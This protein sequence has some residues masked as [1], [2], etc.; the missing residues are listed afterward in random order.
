ML[1]TLG[2]GIGGGIIINNAIYRGRGNAGEIGHLCLEPGGKQCHCGKQGCWEQFASVTALIN[3]TNDAIKENPGS[4]LAG[5]ALT[6]GEVSGE[7]VF[8]GVEQD[9]EVAKKVLDSYV[10]YLAEGINS[11]ISIFDPE[12]ILLSGG[13]SNAGDQ[14]LAPLKEK[15]NSDTVVSVS[16]LKND[17][18]LIGAANL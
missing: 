9:C 16:V 2:T 17:A 1:I 15:I 11:L 3:M 7:T 13:L 10:I 18:G 5:I 4:I 12:M 8:L 14:L 6:S